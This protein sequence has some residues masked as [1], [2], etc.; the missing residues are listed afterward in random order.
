V[1]KAPEKHRLSVRVYGRVQGVGF[2]QFAARVAVGYGLT[3]FVRNDESNGSVQVCAEGALRALELLLRDLNSGPRLSSVIA[4]DASWEP[5]SGEFA[6][7]RI[8]R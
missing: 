2:R 4:V 7:F 6:D 1:G 5:Y 3:G 8:R